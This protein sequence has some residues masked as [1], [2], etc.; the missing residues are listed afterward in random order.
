[1]RLFDSFY[2]FFVIAAESSK[3]VTDFIDVQFWIALL[4]S[5]LSYSHNYGVLQIKPLQKS[6]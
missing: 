5:S 1:M 3:L 2:F 4:K 6:Y